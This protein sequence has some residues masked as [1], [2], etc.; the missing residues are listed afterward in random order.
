MSV[1][2][3]VLEDDNKKDQ[4]WCRCVW[5]P[6][7]FDALPAIELKKVE[8]IEVE[9]SQDRDNNGWEECG[10]DEEEEH[11][12]WNRIS[13]S[14]SKV[15]EAQEKWKDVIELAWKANSE[16]QEDEP[17]HEQKQEKGQE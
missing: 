3:E 12:P 16:E 1:S 2:K 15:E 14:S 6:L 11:V 5:K 13:R 4:Y 9:K 17:K 8:A 7:A 10:Q